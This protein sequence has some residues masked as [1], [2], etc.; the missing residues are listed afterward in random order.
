LIRTVS[1]KPN[2][3]VAIIEDLTE[4]R[5]AEEHSRASGKEMARISQLEVAIQTIGALAHELNQPLGAVSAYSSAARRMASC[6]AGSNQRLGEILQDAERAALRAGQVV[7]DMVSFINQGN[8]SSDPLDL[9][10]LV[11]DTILK[12]RRNHG[13]EVSIRLA[14][15]PTLR[16]V[17]ANRLRIEK[18]L[19]N[20]LDN[21]IEA[22]TEAG[23]S[24][25][26]VSVTVATRRCGKMAQVS[27]QDSGPGVDAQ[28]LE[29]IFEPFFSTKERGL[30]MGLA[31]SRT[32]VESHGGRL[33]VESTPGCGAEFHFTLPFA[34]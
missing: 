14:L 17:L 12:V 22:M 26:D 2:S 19:A 24:R 29:R 18:I 9:N 33:W 21:G 4:R 23:A 6:D 7:Q 16:P 28:Q 10:A 3:I 11:S 31:V 30:G 8:V 13:D 25:E 34:P 5:G 27:V 15:D 20:L 32:I 1:G